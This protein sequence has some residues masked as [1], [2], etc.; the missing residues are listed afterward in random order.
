MGEPAVTDTQHP[1]PT[2]TAWIAAMPAVFVVLWST[3]FIGAKLG[4]PY[5]EPFTFLLVR[6][7][8]VIALLTV[9]AVVFRAPWPA[10]RAE[11]GHGAVVGVLVH[12]VYLGGVFAAIERG[13]PPAVA[14]LIVGPA[15]AA[16][17]SGCRPTIRAAT[18]GGTPRSMAAKT[19]P[20]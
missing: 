1:D 3:G 16:V 15:A 20:R 12:A 4:L 17:S 18:A 7:V 9:I 13:V 14:A 11:I 5:A 2:R 8:A 10:T 19:P 6:F